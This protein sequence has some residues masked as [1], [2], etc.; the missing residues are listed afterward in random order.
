MPEQQREG[1]PMKDIREVGESYY[2]MELRQRWGALLSYRYIGRQFSSMNN[3]SDAT[4][5]LRHDMRNPA[6]GLMAAPLV[7]ACPGGG[8][9]SDL[10]A[11][12]N[13]VIHSL[14]I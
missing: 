12:P 2:W 8:G 5:T 11:V 9:Q 3:V 13:P 7:I 14:Q 6:G 10:H 4:V 1:G